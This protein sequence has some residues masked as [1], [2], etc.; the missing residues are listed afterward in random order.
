LQGY[1]L[2]GAGGA[3]DECVVAEG[4]SQKLVNAAFADQNA[5]KFMRGI[6]GLGGS[7]A[8]IGLTLWRTQLKFFLPDQCVPE[9]HDRP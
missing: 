1:G 3:R 9:H 2:A 8:A 7:S 5:A 4:K 6:V